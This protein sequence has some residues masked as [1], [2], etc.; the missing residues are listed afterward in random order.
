MRPPARVER[1]CSSSIVQSPASAPLVQA[2]CGRR[3]VGVRRVLRRAAGRGEV[4]R[5]LVAD[6]GFRRLHVALIGAPAA[7]PL[8]ADC[9]DAGRDMLRVPGFGEQ[10]LDDLLGLVVLAF[11]EMV[12]ADAGPRRR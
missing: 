11:A 3:G 4:L 5:A 12:M 9:H 10:L 1:A 8:A 7:T 6:V 2:S